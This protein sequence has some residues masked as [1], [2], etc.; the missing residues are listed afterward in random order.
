MSVEPAQRSAAGE[1]SRGHPVM[2]IVYGEPVNDALKDASSK[3]AGR[4]ISQL[5]PKV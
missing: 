4:A 2:M 3:I 5:L 1:A